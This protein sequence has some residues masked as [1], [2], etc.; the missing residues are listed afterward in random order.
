MA[1]ITL[2]HITPQHFFEAV[3]LLKMTEHR[4]YLTVDSLEVR[5]VMIGTS[6]QLQLIND[7]SS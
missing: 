7:F 6:L 3:K 4:I 5:F 1:D 2:S